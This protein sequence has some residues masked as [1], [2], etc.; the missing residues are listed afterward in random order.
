MTSVISSGDALNTVD[1]D[2]VVFLCAVFHT[3]SLERN[4]APKI[5]KLWPSFIGWTKQNV[6]YEPSLTHA[7]QLSVLTR[8]SHPSQLL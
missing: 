2:Y 6:P 5:H 1:G 4:V 8:R 3:D 7:V